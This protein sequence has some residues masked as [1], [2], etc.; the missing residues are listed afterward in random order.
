[1]NNSNR[2]YS[3]SPN[4]FGGDTQVSEYSHKNVNDEFSHLDQ[5]FSELSIGD[6]LSEF[7]MSQS[8][9]SEY[10][11]LLEERDLDAPYDEASLPSHACS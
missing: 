11:G 6:G 8:V 4:Y 7:E 10:D 2:L 5:T 1:M 9:Y 3:N